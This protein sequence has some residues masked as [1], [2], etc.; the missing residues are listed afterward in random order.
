MQRYAQAYPGVFD[1]VDP[2]I[3][4]RALLVLGSTRDGTLWPRGELVA[5]LER[6][7]GRITF[8]EYRRRRT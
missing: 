6:M 2:G 1:G 3:A 4:R 7:A 8:E 5:L